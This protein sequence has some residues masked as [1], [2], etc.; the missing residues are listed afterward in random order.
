MLLGQPVSERFHAK[1]KPTRT[2]QLRIR[3]ENA[4]SNWNQWWHHYGI[5]QDN[6]VRSLLLTARCWVRGLDS[7]AIYRQCGIVG[8]FDSTTSITSVLD[9]L[10]VVPMRV[11]WICEMLESDP[12]YSNLC[13][14]CAHLRRRQMENMLKLSKPAMLWLG[15]NFIFTLRPTHTAHNTQQRCN[16]NK[17]QPRHFR[18][19]D[20]SCDTKLNWAKN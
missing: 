10:I 3:T 6:W 11:T 20:L 4:H 13:L 1:N 18:G 15:I 19:V 7:V 14:D 17:Y 5:R 2:S 9:E 12:K 8:H 16:R